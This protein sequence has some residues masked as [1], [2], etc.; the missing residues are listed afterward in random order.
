MSSC[1][2][3][4]FGCAYLQQYWPGVE[5]EKPLPAQPWQGYDRY[6]IEMYI[7]GS[8]QMIDDD[9]YRD[10]FKEGIA[11]ALNELDMMTE[12][13][14][15]KDSIMRG[16][17]KLDDWEKEEGS[18]FINVF[19]NVE[20]PK[21]DDWDKDPLTAWHD[22]LPV[23]KT[24]AEKGWE[25]A[26]MEADKEKKNK[27]NGWGNKYELVAKAWKGDW[28]VSYDTEPLPL[29]VTDVHTYALAD[30]DE[31]EQGGP[32]LYISTVFKSPKGQPYTV[33]TI[34]SKDDLIKALGLLTRF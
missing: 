19:D 10:G 29:E 27:K 6:R 18:P 34:I 17:D 22:S 20:Y 16:M 5:A 9:T 28:G 30:W 32:G 3:P 24:L 31:D 13:N 25:Y 11:C 7:G 15:L 1:L 26:Q 8:D 12:E 23:E 4:E 14:L 33:Y 2:W 21:K